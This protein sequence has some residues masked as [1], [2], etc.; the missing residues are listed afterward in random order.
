MT[1]E[2]LRIFLAVA[3]QGSM[4]RASSDL[5]L[6]QPAVSAAIA[7]L[8]A[9]SKVKLFDRVGRGIELSAEGRAFVP[10]ACRVLAQADTAREVL[11]DLSREPRG[12]LRI[13][14]SQTVATYWLPKRLMRFATLFPQVDLD[15]VV[16]N[17]SQ[18]AQ[19]VWDGVADL[20]LVEGD[21]P[22][23]NLL[24]RVVGRDELVLI[25]ADGHPLASGTQLSTADYRAYPWVLR[26]AGS[27]TRAEFETHLADFGLATRDLLV[28]LEFPSNEAVLTAVAHSDAL[29]MIS[30]RATGMM[31]QI[32]SRSVTWARVPERPFSLLTHPER[33]RTRA[34]GAMLAVIDETA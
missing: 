15:I 8:E 27:G 17:T 25:M 34:A 5:H 18:V 10:V 2:Q 14:A 16:R 21:V 30:R 20:G 6:T 7:A 24:R 23:D 31:R 22:Q 13:Q 3:E 1:L 29:G 4:T 28:V 12:R 11:L 9:G 33:H 26:E 19:A 32:V